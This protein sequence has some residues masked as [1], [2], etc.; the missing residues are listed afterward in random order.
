MRCKYCQ[1]YPCRKT[2]I[3]TNHLQDIEA[4]INMNIILAGCGEFVPYI[5]VRG[6]G[7]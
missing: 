7:L 1:Q 3:V 5:P 4:I 6:D 2:E